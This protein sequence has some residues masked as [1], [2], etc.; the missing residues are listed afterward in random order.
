MGESGPPC[1]VPSS[2]GRTKPASITPA[3]RNARMSLSTRLSD[4]RAEDRATRN[5]RCEGLVAPPGGRTCAIAQSA[6]RLRPPLGTL[7]RRDGVTPRSGF[8]W[9]AIAAKDTDVIFDVSTLRGL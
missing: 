9:F 4:T 3:L 7:L 2:T 6:N 8:A 1:G 5:R